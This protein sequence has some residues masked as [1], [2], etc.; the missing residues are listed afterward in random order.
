[1]LHAAATAVL[2]V[3]VV[4][5]VEAVV[6]LLVIERSAGGAWVNKCSRDG[7]DMESEDR[8]CWGGGGG[9]GKR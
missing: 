3:L 8:R 6:V 2:V 4:V 9:L 7:S 1:M 5:E